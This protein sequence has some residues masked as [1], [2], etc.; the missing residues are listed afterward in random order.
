MH[1]SEM[2]SLVCLAHIDFVRV[3]DGVVADKV[4]ETVHEEWTGSCVAD[5]GSFRL[6]LKQKDL[7]LRRPGI[8]GCNSHG[9]VGRRGTLMV[10][11]RACSSSSAGGSLVCGLGSVHGAVVHG[12]KQR[13]DETGQRDCAAQRG[14]VL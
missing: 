10:V 6:G 11:V 9:D 8:S 12:V 4:D 7:M 5:S 14:P 13:V 2:I 3:Q 1:L